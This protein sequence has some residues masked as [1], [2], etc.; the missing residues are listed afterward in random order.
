MKTKRNRGIATLF[1]PHFGALAAAT[2]HSR[3]AELVDDIVVH[4]GRTITSASWNLLEQGLVIGDTLRRT[5]ALF[6]DAHMTE[7]EPSIEEVQWDRILRICYEITPQ[8]EPVINRHCVG[9]WLHLQGCSRGDLQVI[10]ERLQAPCGYAT[11]RELSM[12]AATLALPATLRIVRPTDDAMLQQAP[13]AHLALFGFHVETIRLL[14]DI[15]QSNL[16][17][18][19]SLTQRQLQAQFQEEGLRLHKLLHPDDHPLR[20]VAYWD[21]QTI[22]A[23]TAIDWPVHTQQQLHQ[24]LNFVARKALSETT[25]CA[26]SVTIVATYRSAQY[27]AKRSLKYP[28]RTLT[29]LVDLALGLCQASP[30][31]P[32]DLIGLSLSLGRLTPNAAVQTNLFDKPVV[33]HLAIAMSRR[34][35]GKLCRPIAAQRAFLPER[36]YRLSPLMEDP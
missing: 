30:H 11:T 12:I 19:Q 33:E 18:V 9:R 5:R 2:N 22:A 20:P 15:G 3:E 34:F 21:P 32:G 14:L 23:Q 4:D 35:P 28:T 17:E 1:L 7:L 31:S 6:P 36:H 26:R 24:V 27:T 13:T 25:D 10:L 29:T 8:I 16:A